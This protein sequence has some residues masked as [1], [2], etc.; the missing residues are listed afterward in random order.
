[1]EHTKSFVYIDN[2]VKFVAIFLCTFCRRL[3]WDPKPGE[4]HLDAMLRGELLSALALFGHEE[5]Q[6]EASR[7]FHIYLDDRN[8]SLLPPD[9]RRV[10][11][12]Y[13][14]LDI[15]LCYTL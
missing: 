3:G 4:S 11:E 13:M 8:T 14:Y 12:I 2:V 1:M 15:D 7:R 9:L 10:T 6:N 5:T